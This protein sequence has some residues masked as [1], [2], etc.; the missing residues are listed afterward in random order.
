[1]V[2]VLDGSMK[3]HDACELSS[4]A[5]SSNVFKL[6]LL[7]GVVLKF[8]D[9]LRKKIIDAINALPIDEIVVFA[10]PH[11]F[12]L[13]S[14]AKKEACLAAAIVKLDEESITAIGGWLE[15]LDDAQR[16]RLV[17]AILSGWVESQSDIDIESDPVM[18]GFMIGSL[19]GAMHTI[20]THQAQIFEIFMRLPDSGKCWAIHG[21]GKSLHTLNA[22]RRQLIVQAALDME[23]EL[24]KGPAMGG[25]ALGLSALTEQQRNE[26]F[27]AI[28]EFENEHELAT[29]VIPDL[30]K[31]FRALTAEQQLRL[32]IAISEMLNEADQARSLNHIAPALSEISGLQ[33]IS[34]LQVLCSCALS[35]SSEKHRANALG[36][37]GIGF[38]RHDSLFGS[39]SAKHGQ[40]AA[41]VYNAVMELTSED[42][43][44]RAIAGL[45]RGLLAFSAEQR[46]NLIKSCLN[47]KNE[48]N[49]GGAIHGLG[50]CLPALTHEQRQKLINV[51]LSLTDE[52]ARAGA[53]AGLGMSIRILTAGQQASLV[54][55]AINM[56]PEFKGWI[57]SNLTQVKDIQQLGRLINSALALPPSTDGYLAQV[58]ALASLV[59]SD[60][61]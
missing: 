12:A 6:V 15:M 57:I 55:A 24:Y 2:Q 36:Y 39:D 61:I 54:D 30:C 14:D 47:M 19:G 43:K 37:L 13:A 23:D 16:G 28:L 7:G 21:I 59:K 45:G 4:F 58:Q 10:G 3:R 35:M 51:S 1:M 44:S 52:S 17:N 22:R 31:E 27:N 46:S 49:K 32:A 25:V 29:Y 56:G 34:I 18:L 26:V 60:L 40:L 42:L 5:N 38:N 9:V 50:T 20:P 48:I 53:I 41:R 33:Y 8:K 11:L